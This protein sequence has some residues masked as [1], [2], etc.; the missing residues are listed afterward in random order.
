MLQKLKL[1]TSDEA[2]LLKL[3]VTPVSSLIILGYESNHF[4]GSSSMVIFGPLE[5]N[6]CVFKI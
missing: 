6:H 5:L 2:A 3:M 4:T 1:I